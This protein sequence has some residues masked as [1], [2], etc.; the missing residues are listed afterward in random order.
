MVVLV[1]MY[2]LCRTASQFTTTN[3]NN[4]YCKETHDDEMTHAVEL[5]GCMEKNASQQQ[6]EHV[7]VGAATNAEDVG[8]L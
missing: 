3:N 8:N 5:T 7:L 4:E 1:G 6:L 2:R